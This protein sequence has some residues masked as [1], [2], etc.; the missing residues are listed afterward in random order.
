MMLAFLIGSGVSCAAG[1]PGTAELTQAILSPSNDAFNPFEPTETLSAFTRLL[2]EEQSQ[3][4]KRLGNNRLVNYEDIC[5]LAAQ[6]ADSEVGEFENAAVETFVDKLA[7]ELMNQKERFQEPDHPAWGQEGYWR[8][9]VNRLA[10]SSVRTIKQTVVRELS[11]DARHPDA[12]RI[13]TDAAR[14]GEV[15]LDVFTLNHDTLLETLWNLE[16]TSFEDGFRPV[17]NVRSNCY[18]AAYPEVTVWSPQAYDAR[19]STGPSLFKLHGSIDWWSLPHP[20]VDFLPPA[21]VKGD[22]LHIP[23]RPEHRAWGNYLP[24]AELEPIIL[25]GTFNKMLYQ[26]RG[27][28]FLDLL[29]LF[30]RRLAST[31]RLVISGYGFGD[32]GI[33][34]II[35]EWLTSPGHSALLIDPTPEDTLDRGRGAVQSLVRAKERG[36]LVTWTGGF[37]EFEFPAVLAWAK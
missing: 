19:W 12:L 35:I 25:V 31:D 26:A 17:V 33:N 32:K 30:R 13:L 7:S 10:V 23:A 22:P 8:G 24:P 29:C 37:E 16:G 27:D 28:S 9:R 4:L 1:L 2:A 21:K 36:Q 3:L 11:G 5:Y 14:C 34:G 15:S 20:D 6:I 18:L